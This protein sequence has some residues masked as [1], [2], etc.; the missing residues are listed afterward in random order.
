MAAAGKGD[1][2]GVTR[3][4]GRLTVA[5][6]CATAAR[7]LRTPSETTLRGL[8]EEYALDTGAGLLASLAELQASLTA[9]SIDCSPHLGV[10]D[11]DDRRV[12]AAA[13]TDSI[14]AVLE[15][16]AGGERADV[17]FK[18]SLILDVRRFRAEPGLPLSSYRLDALTQVVMKTIAAFCNSGGGTLFV[19]VEDDSTLFGM[20]E[21]FFLASEKRADFDG[22]DQFLRGQ[23]ESRFHDGRVVANYV[24][25]APFENGGRTFVRIKIGDRTGLT[26]LKKAGGG[27]ELFVRSGTRSVPIEFHEIEKHFSVIRKF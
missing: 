25:A 20:K 18:A 19:G 6:L 12:L 8:L 14:E 4:H 26:F 5:L 7:A 1:R 27:A 3:P 22:W 23:I 2:R 16:I 24:K 10:G 11:L 13:S 21:D 15:V 9:F 17:E